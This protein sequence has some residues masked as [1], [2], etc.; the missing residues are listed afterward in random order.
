MKEYIDAL[1][2]KT[3]GSV[4]SKTTYLLN[5]DIDSSSSKNKKAKELAVEIITEK[6]FIEKW[7]GNGGNDA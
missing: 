7:G 2:G 5:N 1:G 6:Q 3:A 4:S